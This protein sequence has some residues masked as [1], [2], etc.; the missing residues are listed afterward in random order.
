M[1]IRFRAGM[2]Y[3]ENSVRRLDNV[4]TDMYHIWRRLIWLAVAVVMILYGVASGIGTTIG[5]LFTAAGCILLP[6]VR[7]IPSGNGN[8]I[9]QVMRD[10]SLAFSYEFGEESLTSEAAGGRMQIAYR[11]LISLVKDERYYYLFQSRDQ[12]CMIDRESLKPADPEAFEKFLQKKTGKEWTRP[13][14]IAKMTL[15]RLLESIHGKKQ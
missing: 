12:A 4:I 5:M 3:D 6:A 9:I 13:D 15:R 2:Q 1:G 14:G 11:D 8:R 10:K 7:R